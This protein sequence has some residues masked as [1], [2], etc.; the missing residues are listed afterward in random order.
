MGNFI[1]QDRYL[2]GNQKVDQQHRQLFD[3]ANQLVRSNN[4]NDLSENIMRLYR[5]V[6]E[7][8]QA[9]ESF[10]KDHAYPDYGQH[11]ATHNLMLDKLIEV[12]DKINKN[13]WQQQDVLTFMHEWI[14]HILEE[15]SAIQDYVQDGS[16]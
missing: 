2:I 11:I 3:L 5:H 15:D 6:R 9:E 4:Q 10:M 14:T 8:F 13:E 12:S 1:W 7:H 16:R